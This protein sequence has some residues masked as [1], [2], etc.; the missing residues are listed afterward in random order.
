MQ[1]DGDLK[2]IEILSVRTDQHHTWSAHH[3]NGFVINLGRFRIPIRRED[4]DHSIV[5]SI[6]PARICI[7]Y[8]VGR[9][10]VTLWQ[11]AVEEG[12][13]NSCR[14]LEQTPSLIRLAVLNA[15]WKDARYLFA[16]GQSPDLIGAEDGIEFLGVIHLVRV[17][18]N[19][20]VPDGNVSD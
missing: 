1:E 13:A 2:D 8:V 4:R 12:K 9:R 10:L 5:G 11:R 6:N 17:G 3:E 7:E 20:P 16:A 19:E 15:G 18:M 14:Y